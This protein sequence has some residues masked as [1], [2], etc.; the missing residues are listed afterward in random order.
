MFLIFQN[1]E[2]AKI[3][4]E[5]FRKLKY[6]LL[7]ATL[8]SA[9]LGNLTLLVFDPITIFIRSITLV[10]WPLLDKGVYFLETLLIKVP[11]LSEP[12][13]A[14]DDWMRPRIFP[15][16]I[17]HLPVYC[18]VWLLFCGHPASEFDCGTI[19]VSL[20]VPFGSLAGA[21][22]QTILGSET[23]EFQLRGM[24][25]VRQ[26]LSHGNNRCEKWLSE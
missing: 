7:I 1:S 14:M 11:F 6:I 17:I 18:P 21:W 5:T 19:L 16:E 9:I 12:V 15:V 3:L 10:I 8:V 20:F 25:I 13:F 24:W 26:G 22:I 4:P 23:G 2:A